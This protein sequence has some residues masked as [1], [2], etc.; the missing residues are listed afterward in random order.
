MM[1]VHFLTR[2]DRFRTAAFEMMLDCNDVVI[3][4]DAGAQPRLSGKS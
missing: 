3:D 1:F 4:R 2:E